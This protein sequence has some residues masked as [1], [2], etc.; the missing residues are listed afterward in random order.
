MTTP[1]LSISSPELETFRIA[2]NQSTI[3]FK[4][5][6][7]FEDKLSSGEVV[8]KVITRDRSNR[9]IETQLSGKLLGLKYIRE[10]D[11]Q[12]VFTLVSLLE[13]MCEFNSF[14]F[15]IPFVNNR[16]VSTTMSSGIDSFGR[17]HHEK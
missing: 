5:G 1:T 7:E 10:I 11:S 9:W 15:I 17:D 3:E 12:G 6:E 2:T 13:G 8:R 14:D 16:L 4:E